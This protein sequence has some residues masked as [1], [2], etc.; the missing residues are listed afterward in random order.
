MLFMC[1]QLI[2]VN[3]KLYYI[4]QNVKKGNN[5]EWMNVEN[6]LDLF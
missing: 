4:S 5:N 1:V 3:I 6:I 2:K